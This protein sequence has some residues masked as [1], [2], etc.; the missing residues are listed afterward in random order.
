VL[1]VGIVDDIRKCVTTDFKNERNPVYI[2]GETRE[3]M[4][5]S[6]L[7]R[8]YGGRGG[9]VPTVDSAALSARTDMLLG[10]MSKGLVRSCH[11]CSD[12]GL[13]VTLAEMC[14]GGDLGFEGDLAG[15]G[16]LSAEVKLFS[17]TASRFV[18]E[19]DDARRAEFES[20]AGEHA[21]QIG[22]VGRGRMTIRDD[23]RPVVD[24]KVPA[25]RKA[26]SEPLWRLLG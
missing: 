22:I 4:G 3:E 15:L 25:M 10:A 9:Q 8:R 1:G 24:V 5:A 12:G 26:W 20:L 13:A 21:V 18:I 11:D 17:E 7:Y 19:V 6:A 14:L 23:R 16:E 2:V